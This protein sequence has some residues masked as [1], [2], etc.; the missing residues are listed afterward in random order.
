MRQDGREPGV[1][2]RLALWREAGEWWSG[3]PYR[4][5]ERFLDA[6]GIRREV[7]RELP[8]L[9]SMGG[10]VPVD[11]RDDASEEISLQMRR[12]LGV[13]ALD[14]ESYKVHRRRL[15]KPIPESESAAAIPYVPLHVR[16]GYAFGRGMI[17]AHEIAVSAAAYG[18]PAAAIVDPISLIGA[19]EFVRAARQVGIHPL[20]GASFEMEEGGE[21]TLIARDARGYRNLSRLVTEC[22]L[23]EP[24][25]FP[26]CNWSRLERWSE[27]L[28][29][30]TG[31]DSGPVDRL[32]VRGREDQARALLLRL[33]R[34][35][36][37][38]DLFVEIERSLLPWGI[39]VGR[40]LRH[41]ASELG[42][43][44]VAGGVVNHARPEHYPA[45]DILACADTLCTV[46]EIVG[47][48]PIRHPDQPQGPSRPERALNAECFLRSPAEMTALF[49]DDPDLLRNTLKVAE[50]CEAEVLPGRVELPRIFED[51][52]GML[53][54]LVLDG[55]RARCEKPTR[56]LCRRLE[57]EMERIFRLG[58]TRHF[59]TIWDACRW[60]GEQGILFSGRGS[61]VDS[62]VAY[63]LGLSR[64][65]AHRH[66]LHFDRFLPDDGTKRPD[67]DI[68]FEAHRRN[69]VRGYLS[70]KYGSEHVATVSA[71]GTYGTRGI[72]REAGKALGLPEE[73][74]GFLAK[75]IHGGVSPESLEDALE[76]R[77]ELRNSSI[78]KERFR[79]V[80]RLGALLSD[81]PRNIRSHSSGVIVSSVP[82]ADIVPV[83]WSAVEDVRIIQW[84]KYSAKHCFD[85]FDILCLRGQDVL[86]GTQ[87]RIRIRDVGF[88][89]E[90]LP[91]DDEETYRTMR[92]GHLIGIPQSAS[93][94][95]RQAHIRLR[96]ANLHDASLVQAGI[97][98]GVGGAVKLNDLIAR[99]RGLK[100]YQFE[101]PDLET[102]LG[103][104][105]GII[106]F[107]EQVDLLLQT[108]CGFTS[109]EAES[110]R[111]AIHERRREDYGRSLRDELVER[112]VSRGYTPSVAEQVLEMVSGF[113]GYGF[114]QGHALA[115]AEISIRSI[116]CQQNFPAEYFASLLDAQ[117]AGYYGPCSLVNEARVRGVA[118]LPVDVDR[119]GS[120]FKV[121]DVRSELDPQVILPSAGIR[122]AL[123]QVAGL[124]EETRTRLISARGEKPY[125]SL[126]DCAAR[127]RPDRDELEALILCGAFDAIHENRRAMLWSVP[128]ALAFAESCR[129]LED[130][131]PL[132]MP[133]PEIV[134]RVEDFLDHEKAIQERRLLGLDVRRH[135][136]AFERER[137][138]SR[139]GI[140][141]SECEALESGRK[142]IVV[143]NP[144]R[145]R[146]PP[147]RSGRRVVFFDLEDETGL[148]NVTCFDDTYQRDGHAIICSPYVTV[149]GEAQDRDGH[150]AFLAHRI[151]PYKPVLNAHGLPGG[152]GLPI[153]TADFL[154]R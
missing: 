40:R 10:Q 101:H 75:R 42:L 134:D 38:G 146:F 111:E 67:I 66:R 20:V 100:P 125:R 105:Y 129:G 127:A 90:K 52:E 106:V 17:P 87:E 24:R 57:G 6:Q 96:T 49:G 30:L 28:L 12:K 44:A 142:A 23:S 116:Y 7:E 43:T 25:Q 54:A 130:A 48:K 2:H 135:L 126:F 83:I 68:D 69:D 22:H 89:V 132:E 35:F 61:V 19:M 14:Y 81:V 34:I 56:G 131:L 71:I 153:T 133:E 120:E 74:I 147:T 60:A 97:R 64:I 102:I 128:R 55:A 79:W 152:P 1:T 70:R 114:A 9:G 62:A 143:G 45:Q 99:R 72:I 92:S 29:C 110:I 145:L 16:S 39:S 31:G 78:P 85:K 33:A 149:I 118:I 138:A 121:E 47:R 46:D 108:F 63:C 84:D 144:I 117:P 21:L 37:R 91:L 18:L 41:L 98:P 150:T 103:H 137:V 104:T 36:G 8:S 94:A 32:L 51:E 115:F 154:S 86:A 26:L 140:T 123:S 113:K 136:M 11:Y 148:L 65:D 139:G 119:S 80:L 82:I 58:Y 151:F 88:E 109:G 4:E 107:Q 53:R 77:P 13:S 122:I 3:E 93:P 73:A 112:M 5:F 59:L 95:M 76:K 141:G 50:R 124:S 27:R 15:R